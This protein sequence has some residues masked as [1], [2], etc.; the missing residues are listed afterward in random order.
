MASLASNTGRPTYLQIPHDGRVNWQNR[1]A[2]HV[3][4]RTLTRRIRAGSWRRIPSVD[5]KADW[6]SRLKS[7][8]H[9][10]TRIMSAYHRSVQSWIRCWDNVICHRAVQGEAFARIEAVSGD[11]DRY[12]CHLLLL[13][14]LRSWW[15]LIRDRLRQRLRRSAL[16]VVLPRLF[17]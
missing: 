5:T 16:C 8:A 11:V 14:R 3:R 2:T 4:L 1:L 9:R 15:W 6:R 7:D 17:P 12:I 10:N 13:I